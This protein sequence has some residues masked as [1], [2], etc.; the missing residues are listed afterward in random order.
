MEEFS[1]IAVLQDF[2]STQNGTKMKD[3]GTKTQKP[4]GTRET[5]Y[6]RIGYITSTRCRVEIQLLYVNL[7]ELSKTSFLTALIQFGGFC[8]VHISTHTETLI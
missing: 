6:L 7:D 5:I 1:F 2:T 4:D 3:K 8:N